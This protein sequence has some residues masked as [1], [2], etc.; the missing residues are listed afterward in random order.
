MFILST[1]K[2]KSLQQWN[3]AV[4][5]ANSVDILSYVM[6]FVNSNEIMFLSG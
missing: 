2:K 6:P 3:T 4:I 1:E 5:L